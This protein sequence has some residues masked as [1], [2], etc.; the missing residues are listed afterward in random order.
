MCLSVLTLSGT[1]VDSKIIPGFYYRVRRVGSSDDDFLFN[2]EPR[3]L[4]SVGMGYGKRITFKGDDSRDNSDY[5]FYSDTEVEGFA[6]IPAVP[7][8]KTKFCMI[9]EDRRPVAEVKITSFSANQ[10]QS[11]TEVFTSQ[12]T[13]RLAVDFVC[14]AAFHMGSGGSLPMSAPLVDCELHGV[15]EVVREGSARNAAKLVRIELVN[16]PSSFKTNFTLVP[17]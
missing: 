3:R 17:V 8:D 15:A 4:T 6:F 10:I 11:S 2:G 13:T 7:E 16:I 1:F 12:I 14:N 5:Y 9:D